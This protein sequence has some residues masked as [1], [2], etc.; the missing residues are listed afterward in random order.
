MKLKCIHNDGCTYW[1]EGN[2]Y[3]AEQNSFGFLFVDDNDDIG[4]QW[5]LEDNADG[6]YSPAGVTYRVNFIIED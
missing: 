6:T 3:T 5:F 4:F 1:T 2:L